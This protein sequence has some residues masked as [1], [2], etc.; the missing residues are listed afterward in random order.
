MA[1]LRSCTTVSTRSLDWRALRCSPRLT[2][3]DGVSTPTA[4]SVGSGPS[5]AGEGVTPTMP[6]RSWTVSIPTSSDIWAT[7]TVPI[8]TTRTSA[9][10]IASTRE[11]DPARARWA[12]S[13]ITPP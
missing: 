12:L 13:G 10:T 11:R 2:S 6:V 8:P 7:A 5:G 4:S 3:G 9:A 1:L